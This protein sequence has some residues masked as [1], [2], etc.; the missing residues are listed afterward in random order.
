M[1]KFVCIIVLY[2]F[3][4][5]YGWGSEAHQ[6]TAKIA[7]SLLSKNGVDLVRSLLSET[8]EALE[9]SFYKASLWADVVQNTPNYAWSRRFHFINLPDRLCDGFHFTRDC[10]GGKCTV[11]AI[12]NYTD[13]VRDLKLSREQRSEALKFLIHF[14]ADVTQPLHIGFTSDAGGNKIT[15]TPPWDH[16]F[17]KAG[18]QIPSPRPKPLHVVWDSHLLQYILV[19]EEGNKTWDHWAENIIASLPVINL[20]K[21]LLRVAPLAYASQTASDTSL[22]SCSYAY[23]SGG[24]WIIPGQVLQQD[25]YD[26]SARI[27]EQQIVKAGQDIAAFINRIARDIDDEMDIAST[28]DE[29]VAE[30]GDDDD[31]WE[32][33][34]FSRDYEYDMLLVP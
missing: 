33:A 27:V 9:E 12:A 29:A 17:N 13:R 6:V 31:Y 24:N 22:L 11:S 15:V 10:P 26:T 21:H 5:S 30:F 28:D 34:A 32:N 23:K 7:L 2:I 14:V 18:K 3:G 20:E 1:N 4:E 25:Y 16:L 19:V 8:G